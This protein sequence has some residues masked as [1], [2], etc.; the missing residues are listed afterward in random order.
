VKWDTSDVSVH[1]TGDGKYSVVRAVETGP[2]WI[3]YR[4]GP[5]TAEQI[6][7]TNSDNLARQLCEDDATFRRRA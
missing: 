6:G 5:T 7:S 3:A 1:R 4:M 2:V